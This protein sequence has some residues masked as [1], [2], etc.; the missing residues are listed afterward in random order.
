MQRRIKKLVK[1][2]TA[3]Q[4]ALANGHNG[5]SSPA[6]GQ[7]P[8]STPQR[9]KTGTRLAQLV[10]WGVMLI[11]LA[12]MLKIVVTVEDSGQLLDII[13]RVWPYLMG[14]LAPILAYYFTRR[15]GQK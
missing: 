6:Q 10:A 8:S 2:L 12:F 9:D 1:V 5:Q 11:C 13:E 4:R 7:A 15:N 3:V 14:L